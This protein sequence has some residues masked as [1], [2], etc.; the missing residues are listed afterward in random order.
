MA[1]VQLLAAVGIKGSDITLW[2]LGVG[3]PEDVVGEC[4]PRRVRRRGD[5]LLGL[6]EL[7]KDIRIDTGQPLTS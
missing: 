1:L 6:W 3:D 4:L 2:P 5:A 7:D